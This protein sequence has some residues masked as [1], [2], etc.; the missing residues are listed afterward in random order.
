LTVRHPWRGDW[1]I[2]K[3]D[4]ESLGYA[5]ARQSL[6]GR[7][8]SGR[9][10]IAL[11]ALSLSATPA[12]AQQGTPSQRLDPSQIE[13]TF[14][15]F[16]LEK[17]RREKTEI[18]LPSVAETKAKPGS[19]P[20]FKLTAVVL[21]GAKTFP[22]ERFVEIYRPYIGKSVSEA[23][24]AE[25]AN[26]IGEVYR[27]AGFHLSR[28]IVPPQEID[29]GVVRVKVVEGAID[30][31]FLKGEGA[32]SRARQLLDVILTEQP[33]RL[34]T[35]ERQLLRVND[36]PGH[37]IADVA[38]EE[39]GVATGRFRLIVYLETWR[40]LAGL[41]L[42][43]RGIE[44]IGPF[45]SHFVSTFNSAFVPGDVIG[46]LFSTVPDS[47]RE[48]TFGQ[49]WY[50]A[51]V[52]L[53]GARFGLLAAYGEIWPSDERSLVGT[54][55]RSTTIEARFT[56]VPLR[57]RRTS[58]WLTGSIG[59]GEVLEAEDDGTLY[60]D[61]LRTVAFTADYQHQDN[62]GA[63]NNLTVI[64]RQGLPIL[65][66]SKSDD[67]FLSRA[68]GDATFSKVQ[69]AFTRIQML[70]EV[71]SVRFAAA[72]QWASTPLLASQEFFLGGQ[73]FGRGYD[74]AEITGDNGIAGSVELR[75]DQKV[76]AGALKM[77]QVYG[78]FD[79]GAVR[80]FHT[81]EDRNISLVSGGGGV[82]WF[83]ADDLQ[84]DVGVAVPLT[85][86]SP[87]NYYRDTRVF[88]LVSKSLKICPERPQARC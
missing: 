38:L 16:R 69:F 26:A 75:F 68:D 1:G 87:E 36:T 44:A 71:W 51:P 3:E 41:G 70:N 73:L 10:A 84:A 28:A 50:E 57:T 78:F 64:L 56:A 83:F 86:R 39:I 21:E 49:L 52:G 63:W 23:D 15:A 40:V 62:Q 22:R 74:T 54:R 88:F 42:D 18:R 77:I 45:Q 58:I 37:R 53:D 20:F 33:S 48:L 65:G 4:K 19:K 30:E 5:R 14:D 80:D 2:R 47:P 24:L 43:N 8:L 31:L 34:A 27:E 35:L 67:P 61:R 79:G 85:Y 82:R 7:F 17:E 72:G 55:T 32:H 11:A 13:R 46:G 9:S 12:G 6:S 29:G 76:N 59:A 81:G 60:R 66:A 25:I